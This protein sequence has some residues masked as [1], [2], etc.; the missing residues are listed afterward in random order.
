VEANNLDLG[1]ALRPEQWEELGRR[2][3]APGS[4]V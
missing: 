1:I 3:A 2:A 4:T